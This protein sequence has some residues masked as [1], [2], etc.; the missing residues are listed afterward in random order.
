MQLFAFTLV[1]L[2]IALE[3]RMNSFPQ[4]VGHRGKCQE[5]ISMKSARNLQTSMFQSSW[6]SCYFAALIYLNFS[7][8]GKASHNL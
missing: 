6:H 4:S 2:F 5:K 7:A 1:E 8:N 3:I